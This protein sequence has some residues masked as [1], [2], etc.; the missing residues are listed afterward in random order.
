[1]AHLLVHAAT[2][3]WVTETHPNF[4]VKQGRAEVVLASGRGGEGAMLH[5]LFFSIH[6]TL[7]LIWCLE[8]GNDGRKREEK[9]EKIRVRK[10]GVVS[11][12]WVSAGIMY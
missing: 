5:D 12:W 8:R 2:P 1:M 10:K 11:L 4:E 6:S 9:G 7:C 3:P